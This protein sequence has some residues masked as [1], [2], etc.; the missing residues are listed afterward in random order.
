MAGRAF[1]IHM[2]EALGG[3]VSRVYVPSM[4]TTAPA[5]PRPSDGPR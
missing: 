3:V 2:L 1:A 5:L 4:L